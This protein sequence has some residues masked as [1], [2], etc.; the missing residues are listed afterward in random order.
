MKQETKK[1]AWSFSQEKL[2]VVSLD[3]QTE[4][5]RSSTPTLPITNLEESGGMAMNNT[6]WSSWTISTDGLNMMNCSKSATDIPIESLSK[7]D[8]DSS[9][10][11]VSSLPAT[12]SQKV[13]T[14]LTTIME[15]VPSSEE[16]T[17]HILDWREEEYLQSQRMGWYNIS[18][19]SWQN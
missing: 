4:L 19:A 16:S 18:G 8:L 15:A 11:S 6:S 2:D 7:E 5:V 9:M 10:Q 17:S 14:S 12:V 3:L 13:G 1:P